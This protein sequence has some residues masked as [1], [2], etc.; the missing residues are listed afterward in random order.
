MKEYWR[1][2]AATADAIR[3][4]WF[5]TG[6][7]GYYDEDGYYWV[8]DRKKNMII[9]GGENIYAA[10]VERVLYQHPALLECALIGLP[11]AKWGEKPVAI[12]VP[13]QD[14]SVTEADL[15]QFMVDKLA[16]YKQPRQYIFVDALPKNAMGKILHYRIRQQ[17]RG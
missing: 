16:R 12:I 1:N 5:H 7:I 10:E 4:G 11:D 15:K 14:S 3:D 13:K 2:P 8:T 9:S 6:D 17:F